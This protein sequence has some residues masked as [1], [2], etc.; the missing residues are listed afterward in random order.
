MSASSVASAMASPPPLRACP[1][2]TAHA[3]N[4]RALR[5][6]VAGYTVLSVVFQVRCFERSGHY[7]A[8]GDRSV[9]TAVVDALVAV[10]AQ[11]QASY[12]CR[13]LGTA[14]PAAVH[15]P[16][17]ATF[18]TCEEH[19]GSFRHRFFHTILSSYV[20]SEEAAWFLEVRKPSLSGD[21]S[22]E[23]CAVTAAFGTAFAP[24]S[25]CILELTR[26]SLSAPPEQRTAPL[27]QVALA[28][29]RGTQAYQ[30]AVE[31]GVEV[32]SMPAPDPSGNNGR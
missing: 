22:L 24:V 29:G 15:A 26:P 27:I 3:A 32:P 2:A 30:Q 9:H 16:Y 7:V 17:R 21:F 14:Y 6:A 28:G 25:V 1:R 11:Q 31:A 4:L 20:G 19:F 23:A 13:L 10:L 18:A 12:C 8:G 5:T